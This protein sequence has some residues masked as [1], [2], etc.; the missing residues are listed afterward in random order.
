MVKAKIQ[1]LFREVHK[2]TS[3]LIVATVILYIKLKLSSQS[4]DFSESLH[5]YS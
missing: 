2:Q 3:D 1:N 5:I 4:R